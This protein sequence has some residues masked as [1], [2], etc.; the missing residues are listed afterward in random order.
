MTLARTGRPIDFAW[1][2]HYYRCGHCGRWFGADYLAA[3][4]QTLSHH[5]HHHGPVQLTL[6]LGAVA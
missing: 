4:G 1:R 3:D 2:E 5:D 6:N